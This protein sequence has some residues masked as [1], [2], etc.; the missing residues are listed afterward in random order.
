VKE[1]IE[2]ILLY[3]P[4]SP[5]IFTGLYFWG[6]FAVVLAVFAVIYKRLAWRNAFLFFVSLFFYYKTSGLFFLLLVFS[7]TCDF[8]LGF[9]IAKAETPVTKR[10]WL[11]LSIVLNLSLLVY[12]KYAYFFADSFNNLFGASYHPV[13]HFAALTNDFFGTTF[14]VDKII[15]P[16]G[17]SFYTFQT[18]SYA[19]DI[20]LNRIQPV[21]SF[22]DFGFYVSFFPQ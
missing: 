5:I 3:N 18:M 22:L 12:F 7:I 20:F 13:N 15:L 19:I 10:L 17:I 11:T 2:Y 16:I 14:K 9:R 21:K 8:L 4:Q 6:F 1:W